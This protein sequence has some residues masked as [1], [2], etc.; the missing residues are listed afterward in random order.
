MFKVGQKVWIIIPCSWYPC[1][2]EIF[3]ISE[4]FSGEDE[5]WTRDG[6][7]NGWGPM[8]NHKAIDLFLSRDECLTGIYMRIAQRIVE[9]ELGIHEARMALMMNYHPVYKKPLSD[10]QILIARN[11]I[12]S[13]REQIEETKTKLTEFCIRNPDWVAP[14]PIPETAE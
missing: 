2:K 1:Q 10:K 9:C 6:G 14:V 8:T 12:R 13:Y 3:D 4:S 7:E 11:H 5:Y